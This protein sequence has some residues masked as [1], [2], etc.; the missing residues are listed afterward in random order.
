MSNVFCVTVVVISE[1]SLIRLQVMQL[2]ILH[3]FE[4]Q[5]L[6]VGTALFDRRYIICNSLTVLPLIPR[7]HILG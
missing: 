5:Q 1:Q 3:G 7:I 2:I 6:V 4:P